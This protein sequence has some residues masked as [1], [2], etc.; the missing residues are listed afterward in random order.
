MSAPITSQE[1]KAGVERGAQKVAY[2]SLME[3]LARV[4]SGGRQR[5]L[6]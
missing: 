2:G 1:I 6:R 5:I 4:L 3:V